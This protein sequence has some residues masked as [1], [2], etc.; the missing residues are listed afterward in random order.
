MEE[1]MDVIA[2][3]DEHQQAMA[4]WLAS[5]KMQLA[6][7]IYDLS[8]GKVPQAEPNG[9]GGFT[10][11]CP[12]QGGTCE[13]N[14]TLWVDEYG[15]I[16]VKCNG[17]CTEP[18]QLLNNTGIL[19]EWLKLPME[20]LRE[21]T[22]RVGVE[23]SELSEE[24]Q[25]TA[26]HAYVLVRD[27]LCNPG[28][29][30]NRETENQKTQEDIRV[31]LADYAATKRP[32]WRLSAAEKP[33]KW[34]YRKQAEE[35]VEVFLYNHVATQVE[36]GGL[37]NDGDHWPRV[38]ADELYAGYVAYVRHAAGVEVEPVG[39][40]DFNKAVRLS[41]DVDPSRQYDKKTKRKRVVWPDLA[42][43]RPLLRLSRSPARNGQ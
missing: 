16:R 6:Q 28:G 40:K 31:L 13:H 24:E 15:L 11:R 5:P 10:L 43:I 42:V 9:N 29:P 4:E 41:Y 23:W 35:A 38:Y 19:M 14:V 26:L 1:G 37:G 34:A 33:R 32:W 7:A 21:R 3:N 30:T 18:L 36:V 2:A 8:H 22:F 39:I 20:G 27:A 12:G 25:W 17:D